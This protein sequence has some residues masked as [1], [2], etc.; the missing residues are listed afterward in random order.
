MRIINKSIVLVG[1]HL[2]HL[3]R[4]NLN[5]SLQ[6]KQKYTSNFYTFC[7]RKLGSC[8]TLFAKSSSRLGNYSET[9]DTYWKRIMA[10]KSEKQVLRNLY[11]RGVHRVY[12]KDRERSDTGNSI[13]YRQNTM[14]LIRITAIPNDIMKT[15]NLKEINRINQNLY[16]QYT[17]VYAI[18]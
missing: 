8:L 1:A 4:Y 9:S 16:F 2:S 6:W 17:K 11:A 3:E 15:C 13:Q 14:I 12:S 7:G 10:S 18:H 5:I